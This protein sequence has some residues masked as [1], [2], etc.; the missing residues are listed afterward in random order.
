MVQATPNI[1][2][3]IPNYL[4]G[5][6]FQ[7][8]TGQLAVTA[9][10]LTGRDWDGILAVFDEPKFAPNVPHIDYGVKIEAGCTAVEW[11]NETRLVSATDAGSLEIWD[12]EERPTLE[13]SV[14]LSEHADICS[15]V[16]VSK[17]TKQ[18]L[19]GSWD[20]VIKLWDLEVDMSIN[21]FLV[22]SDKVLEVKWNKHETNVFGSASEDQT[23]IVYDN[24][25][26]EKP[27]TIIAKT[28]IH[29]PTCLDW[30]SSTKLAVGFSNGNVSVY[31]LRN[32]TG[33]VK[34][35][36]AHQKYVTKI[37]GVDGKLIS[38]SEDCCVIGLE[39]ETLTQIYCDKRHSDY[40]KGICVHPKDKTL[41]SC[42]WDGQI[43]SHAIST[44]EK[45]EKMDD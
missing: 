3:E 43:F 2:Q 4:E 42:G 7:D 15:S 6:T 44:N 37:V 34:T 25:K 9:S 1:V 21:N 41:W 24:R 20:S 10:N 26:D 12:M 35:V 31:D 13:N 39:D 14:H 18:L 11:I 23:L 32:L 29:Y 33:E 22:H 30:L 36:Q 8:S 27:G 38:G 16:S 5:L 28:K 40:V 45:V 17:Q 19:S